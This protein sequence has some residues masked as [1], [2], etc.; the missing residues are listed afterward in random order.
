VTNTHDGLLGWID[1]V[2]DRIVRI[3]LDDEDAQR[4][5]DYVDE[6]GENLRRIA[7]E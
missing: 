5:K 7:N 3:D 4:L 1:N 2:I 6:A